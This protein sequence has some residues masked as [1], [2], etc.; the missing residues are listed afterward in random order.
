MKADAQYVTFTLKVA[1]GVVVAKNWD[2]AAL[3]AISR[4]L[5]LEAVDNLA[6]QYDCEA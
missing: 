4:T 6:K 2:D 5:I 3:T 1:P